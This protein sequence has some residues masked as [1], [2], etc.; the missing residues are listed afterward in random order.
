M[1]NNLNMMPGQGDFAE[2]RWTLVRRSGE[3]GESGALALAE[4]C[5]LYH[6]PVERYIRGWCGDGER[7]RDLT[8][9]FFLQLLQRPRLDGV[10]EDR[11]RFR[12]YLLGAVKHFLCDQ[13]DHARALRRGGGVEMV[14]LHHDEP[15][16]VADQRT[17]P[18]DREFDRAWALATLNQAL[19]E[20]EREMTAQGR[21]ATFSVL[22]PW[23]AGEAIHGALAK[24]AAVLGVSESAVRVAL[25]RMRQHYRERVRQQIAQTLD[26]EAEAR[27]DEELRHLRAALLDQPAGLAGT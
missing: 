16:T 27:V 4:L 23:L 20:L 12:S 6:A 26:G 21:A 18:P 2:T 25:H 3:G 10:A 22:K 13:A 8:Q 5:A 19:V 15:L 14:S 24:A 7:A 17:L 11:G 9:E 1:G